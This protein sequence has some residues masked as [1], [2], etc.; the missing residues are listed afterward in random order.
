MILSNNE[1]SITVCVLTK[2]EE[3]DIEL[4][5]K[6][7]FKEFTDVL[8]VDS[9]STDSTI[10]IVEKLG[11]P[12]IQHPQN[13]PFNV[14]EQRNW[15]LSHL[16]DVSDYVLFVDA[17]EIIPK[18]CHKILCETITTDRSL[19]DCYEIPLLYRLHGKEIKSLGYPNWHD[20]MV[21]TS[22]CFVGGVVGE[23]IKTEN[24]KRI[25]D[26]FFLHD[27]NSKGFDRFVDKQLRYAKYVAEEL[28]S[29]DQCSAIFHRK[30]ISG[31]I[32][33]VVKNMGLLK[34]VLRFFYHYFLRLGFIEGKSG[35]LLAM[36]MAMYE[37]FIEVHRIEIMR[38]R[39][40][41]KL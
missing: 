17:D 39:N 26:I 11:C 24:R 18:G 38:K 36:H 20:R 34:P 29:N 12:L 9:G 21:K 5:L 13:G 16:S 6:A 32:K 8:V 10:R 37:Y 15:C 7:V 30:N 14:T 3:A 41:L 28:C 23:Y 1:P 22:V 35:F 4:C 19:I 25:K 40:G 27:F 2:N 31:K 33:S